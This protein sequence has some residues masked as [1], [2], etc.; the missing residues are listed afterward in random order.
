MKYMVM[1][2]GEAAEMFET[3]SRDWIVAMIDLMKTF[4]SELREAGVLVD[5]QGLVDGRDARTV[6]RR[7]GKAV[8]T[9]GPFAEA[10]ESMVGYWIVDVESAEQ[11]E[12]LFCDLADRLTALGGS[13]SDR[14]VLEIR[15]IADGP[16]EV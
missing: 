9:D 16:P 6:T 14:N 7:G 11:V 15:R 3:Q 5:A 12:A 13:A 1:T 2:F 8:M 4:N 10:K